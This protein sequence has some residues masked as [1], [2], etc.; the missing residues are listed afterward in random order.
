MDEPP[1]DGFPDDRRAHPRREED[2]VLR[3]DLARLTDGIWAHRG[4]IVA[5]VAGI[6]WL[7]TSLGYRYVGPTHDVQ[8]LRQEM[9][10]SDSV[11]NGR[12][13]LVEQRQA[14][15]AE[16]LSSMEEQ[17][18]F[19]VYLQCVA[20]KPDLRPPTCFTIIQQARQ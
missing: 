2:V 16:R 11:M 8:Q 9:R 19:V 1:L 15:I 7:A 4:K 12:V 6:T 10:L 20:M 17:M 5:I 3:S 14:R 18:R 13:T